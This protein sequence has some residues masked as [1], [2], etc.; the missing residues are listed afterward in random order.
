MNRA[1]RR[2]MMKTIPGYK[3]ALKGAT[4]KTVDGLEE[5]FK[6]RWEEDDETLNDGN[7]RDGD[8]DGEDDIYND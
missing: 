3:D 6:K 8:D 1:E 4:Q 2:R 5:M 7:L